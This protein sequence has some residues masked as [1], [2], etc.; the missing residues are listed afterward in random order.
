M[1]NNIVRTNSAISSLN[2]IIEDSSIYGEL[3]IPVIKASFE[4]QLRQ[5]LRSISIYTKLAASVG[6]YCRVK[7]TV[8]AMV[9]LHEILKF[10]RRDKKL[11]EILSKEEELKMTVIYKK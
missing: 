11:L 9:M 8:L 5:S 6:Y 4:L 1:K 10:N 2:N 3:K 7:R